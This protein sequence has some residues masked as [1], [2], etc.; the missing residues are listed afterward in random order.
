[1]A[2]LADLLPD[3][4]KKK[5]IA[6]VT[7]LDNIDK[8][9]G[10]T[11]GDIDKKQ[12]TED[13]EVGTIRSILSGVASGL[14]KIPEGVVSLGANLIDLGANTNTAASVEKFFAKINP[15][16]EAAEATAAGK[17]TETI[18]NIGIPGGIAFKAGKTFA[19]NALLA[20]QNGK[21]VNLTGDAG[22]KLLKNIKDGKLTTLG[23]TVEYGAGAGLGGIAEGVF[24]GDVQEA[25]T[26]GNLLGGPTE[27]SKTDEY[28]AK[29]A[30]KDRLK[31]GI[32]GAAFT[33]ILGAGAAGIKKLRNQKSGGKVITNKLDNWIDKY[34]SQPLRARGIDPQ[35]IFDAKTA[36]EGQIGK[37]L[38]IAR[39]YTYDIDK[40]LDK[41]FPFWKRVIGDKTVRTERE[42]INKELNDVLLSG[43]G[44]N[45]TIEPIFNSIDELDT[46]GKP[47]GKKIFNV[48]FDEMDQSKIDAFKNKLVTK[49]QANSNDVDEIVN[50]LKDVRSGWGSLFSAAGKRLEKNSLEDFKSLMKEKVPNFLNSSYKI[51]DDKISKTGFQLANNYQPPRAL[52]TETTEQIKNIVKENTNGKIV[53]DNFEAEN[54]VENIWKTSKLPQGFKLKSELSFT[55]PDFLKSSFLDK[56]M[57]QTGA[58]KFS[59]LTG[60]TQKVIDKLLG[61]NENVL[62]TILQGT[63]KLSMVVRSNQYFDELLKKSNEMQIVRATQIDEFMKQ[64]LTRSEAEKKAI[65]PL[66]VDNAEE[67]RKIYGG[68]DRDIAM[69][70]AV[71]SSRG[72]EGMQVI[73]PFYDPSAAI[74]VVSRGIKQGEAQVAKVINPLEGKWA[75][76]DTVE[77]LENIKT[78]FLGDGMAAQLYQN[79]ILYPKATSQLAKTVL[80]PVTHLRN[81]MSASMFAAANGMMPFANS[82]AI[83][84]AR[85]AVQIF[86][87]NKEGNQLYQR[88][89][90]L[91]VV[92]SNVSVGDLTRLLDDV[93]F[94]STLGQI[95]IFK[96][97][98]N[99]LNKIQQFAQDAYT[100]EDDFWKIFTWFGEKEKLM[101]AYKNA[102]LNLGDNILDEFGKKTGKIFNEQF[103]ELEA[104]NMVKNQVPNYAYVN[105][106][107]KALRQLP[108]GNFV[109]FPSEMLRTT[110]NIVER[111]INEITYKTMING[112][113]VSP[114][115][116]RGIQRLLG[117]GITTTAVPYAAVEA[118]KAI[119]NVSEDEINAMRRYVPRW[120]KNSTLIPTRDKDGNLEYIDFSHMNA[121]DTVTRPIQT[122]INAVQEGRADKDGLMDDFII[123]LAESTK[124]L[125]SPFIG[126]SIWTEALLDVSPIRGGKT[127]EGRG[128]WNPL[129]TTGDKIQKALAHL[130]ATQVPLNWKQLERLGLSLKP[131]DSAGRFNKYGNEFELGNELLGIVGLRNVKINP[132]RGIEYKITDYKK[133]IRNARSLFTTATTK[134]GPIT[135]EEIVD[136][137]LNSN[138]ALY[139]VNREFYKDIEAAKIL[140]M[141][142]SKVE[143]TMINRGERKAYRAIEQ[144]TFRPL[145]ISQDVRQLFEKNARELGLGNPFETAYNE[146]QKLLQQLNRT[147]LDGDFFPEL[148]NPFSNL[149]EPTL[150][151]AGNIPTN[152]LNTTPNIIGAQNITLPVQQ[153][154]SLYPNDDL[155]IAYLDKKKP[156]QK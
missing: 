1:M 106:F 132:E 148:E 138:R 62:S 79:L 24:V 64:G 63:N 103:L 151:P 131:Q 104:A 8:P 81:F 128:I 39:N 54:I 89:L 27:L 156:G 51:F 150:G 115:K 10:I 3:E 91:G 22:Q 7:T 90:E 71:K 125:G 65:A 40:Q 2:T 49:F 83:K 56:T 92:N 114:L 105:N 15:F 20:R 34:I 109:S 72:V 44:K 74:D 4:D 69:V 153:Y 147:K 135:P 85:Q 28:N 76:A 126:E 133:G 93:K 98:M 149:P 84:Q 66:F 99:R 127:A 55:G 112:Q 23:K 17:I 102:G 95:K 47:T 45:K 108:F 33:G 9:K 123:G 67:A 32:E 119:Y 142:N 97:F 100:A 18:I 68:T 87:R 21:Y 6:K 29:E 141:T 42:V 41:L 137:Y 36:K 80:G 130:G 46:T 31:F 154:T 77:A 129:D 94:G 5:N 121:Y 16:D 50:T 139:Q 152:V 134:G 88:L 48:T 96:G 155:A 70:G 37:D 14:F 144:N 146:I 113:V 59:E 110:T 43:S 53:L 145:T 12:D 38:N 140:G 78:S 118:G 124:E 122:I 52:I 82:E 61:R 30:L 57:R 60:T 86:G 25:G 11:L 116:G 35:E 136:A 75:L 143:E 117:L 58:I 120:S 101:S 19:R 111:A 107:I 26:F 13:K 73:D